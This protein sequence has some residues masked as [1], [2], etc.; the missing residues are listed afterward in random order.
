MIGKDNFTETQK[1][2]LRILVKK[3]KDQYSNDLKL[4]NKTNITRV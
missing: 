2:S 3:L 4:Q 1:T